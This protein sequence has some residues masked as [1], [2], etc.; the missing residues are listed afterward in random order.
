[1]A[2]RDPGR[3]SRKN[4]KTVKQQ[5]CQPIC[6]VGKAINQR[7]VSCDL[8]IVKGL[9]L[10]GLCFEPSQRDCRDYSFCSYF[11]T[12]TVIFKNQLRLRYT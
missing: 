4:Q 1:M 5:L 6:S 3:G 8:V 12:L 9:Q 10:V 7:E 2:D 11:Y